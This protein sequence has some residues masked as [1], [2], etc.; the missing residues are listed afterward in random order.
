MSE[1]L[2]ERTEHPT[3][4]KMSKA[5]NE[6]QVAKSP[7]F[8]AALDMLGAFIIL[9][10]F[11]PDLI[12][13]ALTLVKGGLSAERLTAAPGTEIRP[14]LIWAF[15]S[16][17][18]LVAPI[19]GLMVLVTAGAQFAQ[20][21]W[22]WTT[23]PIMPKLTRLNPLA[24]IKRLINKRNL[25]KTGISL[26]K[27][28]I[29]LTIAFAVISSKLQTLAF[30]PALSGLASLTKIAEI[31]YDLVIWLLS[32]LLIVGLIDFFY[33]R[34]Q[35]IQDL[36]MTKQ[37]VK[38]ERR[39][40][41]GDE[42]TKAKRLRMARNMLLQQMQQG[43]KTA[44]VIVTNPTHFAVAIKYDPDHMH[45]PKVVAKGADFMAFRIREMANLY[46]VPIVEKP[47]LAR[48]LYAGVE[49]GRSIAPEFYQAVAEILA[50]VYRLKE[51]AA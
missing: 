23:K 13:G 3:G 7:E 48:G 33:Q 27:L 14:Y 30:L 20:V 8:S 24:G 25:I 17:M 42:K 44:D 41:E 5:R 18:L 32:L 19:L 47:V 51:R 6:G 46:G 15:G 22:L 31:I 9:L 4:R 21:G 36:R 28:T 11:G 12:Q 1:E 49:V 35:R 29:I 34:W 38:E 16:G 37:E 2:G 26:V 39:S 50:Y 45:A 10:V 43:V 40:M